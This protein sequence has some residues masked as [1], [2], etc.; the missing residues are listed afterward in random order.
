M[1]C[2]APTRKPAARQEPHL[3]PLLQTQAEE[4]EGGGSLANIIRL[5]RFSGL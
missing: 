2:S 5:N 3:S 4:Q 1:K